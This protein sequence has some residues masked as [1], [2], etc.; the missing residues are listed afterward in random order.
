MF[1]HEDG[2]AVCYRMLHAVGP[3]NFR[4]LYTK[5]NYSPVKFPTNPN[6]F[7]DNPNQ[8]SPH[9]KVHTQFAKWTHVSIIYIVSV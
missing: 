2:N 8:Q 6:D 5:E 3:F 4:T 1:F 7:H 9:Q